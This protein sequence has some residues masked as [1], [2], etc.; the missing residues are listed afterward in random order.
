MLGL[1]AR[2][3]FAIALLVAAQ[4]SAVTA[5]D[6]AKVAAIAKELEQSVDGL[7]NALR[8]S[9]QW[10]TPAA[11]RAVLYQIRD[12][13]RWME[14]EAISL[15]AMLAKGEGQEATLNSYRRIQQL[16]RETQDLAQRAQTTAFIQPALD[17]AKAALDQLAAY[18]PAEAANP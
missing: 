15:H 13:L 3:I 9:P 10:T 11:P 18:Y 2:T 5:W 6:Q 8:D 14:S 17:K 12:N 1:A 7:R 16:R 4:A